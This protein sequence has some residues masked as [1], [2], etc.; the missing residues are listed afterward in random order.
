MPRDHRLGA[1]V[2]LVVVAAATAGPPAA[3]Q[4]PAATVPA[5]PA[6]DW[7]VPG[8]PV[9]GFRP[10]EGRYGPGHRGVD[11]PV[12]AGQP[13]HPMADG[14][15]VFSGAVAGDVWTTVVHADGVSTTY[16]PM[17]LPLGAAFGAAVT[18]Q[19]VIGRARG[20]AHGTA[21][22]L[23]VG[24]RRD[25]RYV[26]PALL[27]ELGPPLVA[28]LDGP[29]EVTADPPRDPGRRLVLVPGTPP[30]P[31]HVVVL[32]GLTS[33]TGEQPF[34]LGDLGYGLDHW[35]QFS[36][37][38]VD[39]AGDPVP[40]DHDATWGR[41]HDM[42][43]ALRDQLRAH[44]AS[45]PG[46]AVDLLGHSLGGLVGLY[47]L[48]V[49]HDATDPTLPPIGNAVTVASPLG[50]TDSAN[51]VAW[52]RESP[53][54]QALLALVEAQVATPDGVDG[55]VMHQDM[56]VLDDLQTDSAVVAALREA[57]QRARDDPWSS[58]LAVGTDVLTIG[59]TLDP[60]VNEHRSRLPGDEHRTVWDGDL[61]DTHSDVTADPR[62][63][64]LLLAHLAGEP[65]PD[66]GWREDVTG[67]LARL[68]SGG[69]AAVEYAIA[70][71]THALS[72][73]LTVE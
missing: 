40:Y 33:H 16:G 28:T 30:S 48:L 47:Y 8:P 35:Q 58:P 17:Q 27:V 71:G 31:N 60:I 43:L 72:E 59:S 68:G 37:R 57:W 53:V 12:R 25:G 54:G 50:G 7:P 23:H 73:L 3:A 61:L 21:G 49:L 64:A 6:Y 9:A 34:R 56:P 55:P 15:V 70:A 19:D 46:Q 32:A 65:L 36:Y 18:R 69:V 67:T 13:V 62:V 24:A 10:P 20:D 1:V 45:H 26:D 4:P 38:G 51:A 41:V 11:L 29:G 42:A 44:A 5:A 14:V 39:A 22:R 63:E 66:R 52:A 2:L